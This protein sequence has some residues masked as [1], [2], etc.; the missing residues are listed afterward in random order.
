[1]TTSLFL[2]LV[3]SQISFSEKPQITL[4]TDAFSYEVVYPTPDGLMVCNQD[5]S[6]VMI[7]DANGEVAATLGSGGG[8]E[9]MTLPTSA[10]WI[11]QLNQYYVYDAAMRKFHV[12]DGDYAYVKTV[13]T[14]FPSF[15]EVGPLV[16]LGDGFA[17]P[18]SLQNERHLLGHFDE[19]FSNTFYGYDISSSNLKKLSPVLFKPFLARADMYGGAR[20]VAV[21]TLATSATLMDM[22]LKSKGAVSLAVPGWK[23]PEIK[24]LRKI[25]KN[26]RELA[27][28][29]PKYSE[30]VALQS[31][32]GS[33]FMV[34]FRN[35]LSGDG[36]YFQ[37][38]DAS[39]SNALGQTYNTPHPPAGSGFA[40][41]YL[42]P[43]GKG[44]QLIPVV[45]Q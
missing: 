3:I 36:Y 14:D 34:G 39:T 25:S 10:S 26:P 41:I 7:F 30:L 22:R 31:I 42:R 40:R 45:V 15:F 35:I 23:T 6:L 32:Q 2:C 29:K 44:M 1:M 4:Q 43:G 18:V 11:S 21:Q 27:K 13:E 19:D 5:Q 37:C 33:L 24:K 28:Y 17:A 12:W 38:Y 16:Y 8:E 9:E 20:L